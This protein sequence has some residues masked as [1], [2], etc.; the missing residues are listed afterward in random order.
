MLIA[1]SVNLEEVLARLATRRPVFHSEAD[2]QF[3][4]AWEVREADPLVEVFLETRPIPHL[5][6][7]LAFE[8]AGRYT[9]IE[10]K[11]PTRAW[12]GGVN[13][14]AYHLASHSARDL[15]CYNVVK[16][17]KRVED[18]VALQPGANGAVV[19]VTND[20]GYWASTPET[21]ANDR[22]FRIGEGVVLEGVRG[23]LRGAPK[24]T[25]S[26][27]ALDLRDRYEM[28]WAD[29]TPAN[30]PSGPH[31]RQLVVEVQRDG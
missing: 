14:Q 23:W 11:Y 22:D 31:F 20:P 12:A 30:E 16:D 28:H 29:Y 27:H 1:G 21:N 3:A 10:L 17:V 6:L 7:D 9:A 4:L 24:G 13:G 15:I 25:K 5:H 2:F 8:R 18:F 19:V 26:L